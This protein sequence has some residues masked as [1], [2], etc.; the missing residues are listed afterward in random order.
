M[1]RAL[2]ILFMTLALTSLSAQG[3]VDLDT[4]KTGV[5]EEYSVVKGDT[6]VK[7]ADK[8]Y[9][10]YR[11]WPA[12][13]WT[14][15]EKVINP[16]EIE[17]G[18]A[19]MIHSLPFIVGNYGPVETMLLMDAYKAV[20][21]RY[22]ELDG[23][24]S[25][26]MHWVL[27]EAS[28]LDPDFV[29]YRQNSIGTE[30]IQW[31]EERT[32]TKVAALP[33]PP[34]APAPEPEAAPGPA[35][36][37]TIVEEPVKT[38]TLTFIETSDIHGAIFPYNFITAKPMATSLAQ[39]ATLVA[40]ERAEKSSEVILM[41]D[42]DSLQG[43]PTVYYYNFEK[44]DGPHIWS[45]AMNYLQYNFVGVG[46][47][48]IEAGHPVYDK[49]YEELQ[50]DVLCA[51][52]VRESD[53]SPYFMPYKVIE[54]QG[55]KIA[56][57]GMITPK[58]PD[59]LPPQFWTGIR[60]EDM[61]E[62]AKKWVP[63]I[64]DQE[65]PDVLVGLFH[66]GVDYSYGGTTKDTPNN[67]NAAQLVAEQVPGFDFILVGHDHQSWDGMGWDPVKKAK[68]EVK[69]PNGKTVY[70]YGALNDAKK[71]PVVKVML[72]WDAEKNAWNKRVRGGLIDMTTYAP[73]PEFVGKFQESFDAVKSWVDR[74]VGKMEG[75]I[76]SQD[77]MFGDSAF[78]DLIHRIQLEL[79]QD[80]S[81][82]L[83]PAQ[84][85]FAA[86]LSMNAVIPTSEDG[87]L[88]VRDMFN[89]Y[90]YE[91]FLYTMTMTGQ[92]IKDF[93]EYSYKFWF[94]TMP[95][96][97]MHIINFQKTPD[98]KLVQDQRT[99]FYQTATR[100]YNY[101][102]AAGITYRVDVTKP[103]GQRIDIAWMADGSPFD[104]GATYTV[105]INSYRGQGGGGHL[106][107]GA[108]LDKAAV[109]KLQFVTGA[110]TKDLR[111]FLLKWFEKQVGPVTVEALG[112]WAV[113]PSELADI[114]TANDMPLLYPPKK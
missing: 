53:G 70:I 25:D 34:P 33:P 87:T 69:D 5:V 10:D 82:G 54:R 41:D 27:L 61:V 67:E 42:G 96:D 101:D 26:Q 31:Y 84:I 68:V 75:K 100:Y 108:G 13:W 110:T 49:L 17:V 104:L 39:V 43:Q 48:D 99:G 95:N 93:L 97:G 18:D 92:Q 86:P 63:I 73:D 6:I 47:H 112:N 1:R 114:G 89:L 15:N 9:G 32:G 76:S 64:L 78:V 65:K 19:L 106:T 50:A 94:D 23:D 58:I 88:Y 59:W 105:A 24:W 38:V 51:N 29:Y 77:S 11:V 91:N 12:F 4:F 74:P 90:V 7:I 46:N 37:P 113:D 8:V 28:R 107:T 109:Q 79:S 55:V 71:I 98:G 62:T 72:D 60:F 83:Q 20:Y 45:Q 85:S 81:T 44:T 103:A 21:D 52:A 16:D 56:V 40:N 35:P 66:A 57:L 30:D 22:A 102:S 14:N 111:Y 2:V 3:A 36:L 80:P